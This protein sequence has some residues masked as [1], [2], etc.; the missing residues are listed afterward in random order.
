MNIINKRE[1]ENAALKKALENDQ[2]IEYLASILRSQ[3]EGYAGTSAIK[4]DFL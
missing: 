3:A 1:M 2:W 4:H